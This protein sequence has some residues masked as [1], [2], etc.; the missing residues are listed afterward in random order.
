M[1]SAN[2]EDG[3][4][5]EVD[6][7]DSASMDGRGAMG[8]RKLRGNLKVEGANKGMFWDRDVLLQSIVDW[9]EIL[10]STW[11]RIGFDR[12]LDVYLKA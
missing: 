10:L 11:N 8:L 3:K 5:D 12:D 6:L 7:E 4:E 1:K 2:Q 9:T